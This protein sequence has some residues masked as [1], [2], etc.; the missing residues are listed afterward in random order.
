MASRK[1]AGPPELNHQGARRKET[2]FGTRTPSS[3]TDNPCQAPIVRAEIVGSAATCAGRMT[4][5]V[6]SSNFLADLA[7][8]IKIEHTAV[9]AALKDSVTHAIA[10]GELLIEAKA[11]LVHGQWLPWLRDH[12]TMSERTAQLYMR[13]AKNR[14]A[15][16]GQ[17]RNGVADLSLNEAAAILMLSSDV[18]KLLDYAKRVECADP[19][20][21]INICAA[22]GIA[23]IRG[24]PFGAKEWSELDEAEVLEWALWMLL[25]LKEWGASFE[26]VAYYT[27]RLQSRGWSLTGWYGDEGDRWR[28]RCGLKEQQQADK[29]AWRVFY[30]NNRCRTLD[31]VNAEIERL[32]EA[33]SNQVAAD[34]KPMR[35]RRG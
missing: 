14:G 26:E 1:A 25:G 15:I 31:D 33:R 5:D 7:G 16:E 34:H 29:D 12:C 9:S 30:E 23:V 2:A 8:R 35:A 19:E 17:I 22:D 3:S 21:L 13:C 11:Q 27:D 20:E 6:A 24:N 10:A 4:A 18:R 28:A 32:E